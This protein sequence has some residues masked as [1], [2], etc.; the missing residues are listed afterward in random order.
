MIEIS[1]EK[2]KHK[3]VDLQKLKRQLSTGNAMLFTGAGFS[4]GTLNINNTEPPLATDLANK[5]CTLIDLEPLNDLR[6]S[7]NLFMKYGDK[8]KLIELLTNEFTIN[9]VSEHHRKISVF[10]WRR[11]YTTN[12]DNALEFSALLCGKKIDALDIDDKPK[13]YLRKKELI[14]HLNGKIDNAIESDLDSKIKLTNA[15]YLSP[16]SFVTSPWNT[17]FKR[18]LETSSA[19]IFVGYSMYDIELQRIL[20]QTDNLVDK[21]YFIV[22]ED[23]KFIDTVELSDFGYVLPIGVSGFGDI[24]EEIK[25]SGISTIDLTSINNFE[26]I[27]PLITDTRASD[28]DIQDFLLYA[29][30]KDEHISN[31][32]SKN[33]KDNF[34]IKRESISD[35]IKLISEN[36]N[37]LLHSDLGNGKSIFLECL[38][39]HLSQEGYDVYKYIGDADNYEFK[40]GL[41]EITKIQKRVVII[42]DGYGGIL[43]L[44][45]YFS[46]LPNHNISLVI[47]ERSYAAI[48]LYEKIKDTEINFHEISLDSLTSNEADSLSQ[49]LDHQ[50]LWENFTSLG[51]Q[52]KIQKIRTEYHNQI[53][54]VLLGLLNS[55]SITKKIKDATLLTFQNDEYKRTIFCIAVCDIVN[56]NKTSSIISTISNSNAIYDMKFRSD[57]GFR[58]LYA[59]I[60]NGNSIATKSSLMSLAIV[61]NCF[62][63][64]YI[65]DTLLNIVKNLNQQSSESYDEKELFK[66]LLRF[67]FVERL[68]PQKQQALNNYYMGLKDICAWLKQSPHYW[69]QY[70]MCRLSFN[71]YAQ[72]QTYLTDAYVLAKQRSDYHTNN[73]DTQQAR[74]YLLQS[75][76]SSDPLTS[77]NF[78]KKAHDILYLLPN[79]GYKYRQMLPYKE[80]YEKC[81]LRFNKKNRVAFEQFCKAAKEQIERAERDDIEIDYYR[82]KIFEEQAL[83]LLTEIVSDIRFKVRKK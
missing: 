51:Q 53:S 64:N 23:S 81:Y 74:L 13:N 68:L 37:I 32:V 39:Y 82:R 7:S 29:K 67:H 8:S 55:P 47:S 57:D 31:S 27:I 30:Y 41:D 28:S 21:T 43:D 6:K 22:K 24:L 48:R 44:I 2:L 34:L 19:I 77:F 15:S 17:V 71:D 42:I 79:D 69:V 4:K 1:I 56:I 36:K 76:D 25:S 18:D 65:K 63:E 58:N 54:G 26:K 9:Q 70:A 10:P 14:I 45:N 40:S 73:I 52:N 5:I 60:N 59:F 72:A 12:Y 50:G 75:I 78:F 83:S 49:L 33:Y 11:I 66:S 46:V 3:P 35:T 38:S 80:V 61:N 16:D 20:Y 62:T